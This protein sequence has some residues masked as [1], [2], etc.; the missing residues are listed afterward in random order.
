[1]LNFKFRL[2]IEMRIAKIYFQD[3]QFEST[4]SVVKF[5]ASSVDRL[6][7]HAGIHL[8]MRVIDPQDTPTL[9]AE[10]FREF[11]AMMISGLKITG[12]ANIK[13]YLSKEMRA[14]K[15]PPALK[16]DDESVHDYMLGEVKKLKLDKHGKPI[17]EPEEDD[18]ESAGSQ[19][20]QRRLAEM[21]QRRAAVR[22]GP[23]GLRD[24]ARQTHMLDDDDDDSRG[25][26]GGHGNH[27]E[28]GGHGGARGGHG[29]HGDRGNHGARGHTGRTQ[30]RRPG[31]VSEPSI[32]ETFG[33]LEPAD[34]ESAGDDELMRKMFE[35][36]AD[37]TA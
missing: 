12:A 7:M 31:N 34:G 13:D 22:R 8:D 16:T 4:V 36:Q 32:V 33:D 14:R 29:G 19:D 15:A 3:N 6:V 20:M 21:A 25:N 24:T 1:M 28:R 37:S 35:S 2:S 9:R 18:D 10:G 5:L 17:D 26:H 11:P 30:A 23:S 27:G